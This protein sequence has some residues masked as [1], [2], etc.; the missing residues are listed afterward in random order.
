MRN[1]ANI[2]WIAYSTV[3]FCLLQINEHRL[4]GW[5]NVWIEICQLQH[6]FHLLN[7]LIVVHQSFFKCNNRASSRISVAI[8]FSFENEMQFKFQYSLRIKFNRLLLRI[9]LCKMW[10]FPRR[11]HKKNIHR[12]RHIYNTRNQWCRIEDDSDWLMNHNECQ[13]IHINYISCIYSCTHTHLEIDESDHTK[14]VANKQ[15]SNYSS[16]KIH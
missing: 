16:I 7:V 13:H 11:I 9:Q 12:H 1:Y 6:I 10:K 14:W 2:K 5:R 8:S 3:S 4:N 15:A